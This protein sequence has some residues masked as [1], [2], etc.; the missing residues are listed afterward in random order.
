MIQFFPVPFCSP[1][2]FPFR[3]EFFIVDQGIIDR[4]KQVLKVIKSNAAQT[5]TLLLLS[6]GNTG[7]EH[8]E[9]YKKAP[10]F[11]RHIQV[12]YLI[13]RTLTT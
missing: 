3:K 8:H 4:I 2:V 13:S 1:A 7:Y 12:F 6:E 5:V 11:Q 10:E 9:K